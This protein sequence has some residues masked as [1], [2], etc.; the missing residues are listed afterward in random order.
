MKTRGKALEGVY[1]N[2]GEQISLQAGPGTET[3]VLSVALFEM[4]PDHK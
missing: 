1:L 2:D 3:F 4:Y